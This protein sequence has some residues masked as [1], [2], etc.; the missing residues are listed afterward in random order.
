MPGWRTAPRSLVLAV[1]AAVPCWGR[2]ESLA[3]FSIDPRL[4]GAPHDAQAKQPAADMQSGPTS[5]AAT[6]DPE[7]SAA[8]GP[9]AQGAASPP[10]VSSQP[11]G[12][13]ADGPDTTH[14][15]ARHI[16]GRQDVDLQAYDE[17]RLTRGDLVMT[18]D[19]LFYDQLGNEVTAEGNVVVTRRGDRIAGP[20]AHINLDTWFGEFDTPTYALKREKWVT[21]ETPARGPVRMLRT[22]T[23]TGQADEL[24][25]EGEN[26]YR[27]ANAT[28]S[29][30]PAP[31]PDWYM[32]V[33]DLKLDY[34]RDTGTGMGST[35]VFKDVPIAYLPWAEF[36]LSG[37]RQ[38]GFLPPTV[39]GTSNTGFDL[40][41]PYY[42]N[43]APNYDA[44]FAPRYMSRRG[45]QFG[46]ET[47]YLTAKYH[48][49]LRAEWLP[50][51]NV[52][53]KSRAAV[54]FNHSQNF[55]NGL[56]A[57]V[58]Y[59]KVTDK[60]YFADL[61]SRIGS[62]SQATLNRQLLMSYASGSWL[63][64]S[65]NVQR[66]Q[67]LT[68]AAPYDRLPQITANA[69]VPDYHGFSLALPMQYARFAHDIKDEASRVVLYPQIGF[70]IQQSA[71]FITPKVGVHLSRYEVDRRTTT[72]P[73]S[74]SRS[75]PIFSVDSGL[76]FE[77]DTSWNGKPQIQT[78]E[79]RLYYVRSG[80]TDQS[81]FPVFDSARADFNFAQIF[82]E[83]VYTG[84]DRI[85]DS[86]QL[87]AAVQ[88]RLID[89]D[90]G[91]EWIRGGVGQRIYFSDQRVTLPGEQRRTGRVAD[92]LALLSGRV[93]RSVWLD[94]AVQYDPRNDQTQRAT[95]GVR[96]QP[97]F[98]KVLSVSYRFKNGEFRDLD[99][100]AQ[101]PL[102]QRW[103]GV[104]RYNRNLR[105]HRLTEAIA[106]L[107]YKADCW[108]FRGVWQTL[109]N[110]KQT[111]NDAFFLQIE[112]NGLASIGSS[113]LNLLK[114]SVSG[115]GKINGPG[116][117]D[118]VFG[119]EADD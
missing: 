107:E 22:V 89:A 6:R 31:D 25:L 116:S 28:Y 50:E 87:T 111:R 76:N 9:L 58:T 17:V 94:G 62:T 113:P 80:Y 20:R 83:N 51:D 29:S 73:S 49:I 81:D 63:T 54:A 30:C 44:T 15:E 108:V 95:V 13:S 77:R 67:T 92:L 23:A 34:D 98:A 19:K 39:G 59:N 52:A 37:G 55:G 71:F 18:S 97:D 3:P 5:R 91:E 56:A 42:F 69:L 90:T 110:T 2:A 105:D 24:K 16:T 85:A 79:P 47:R 72:G 7:V 112:F 45:V 48:G 66:Y 65:L 68:G 104:G 96:Y 35:L 53:Q 86:N 61:S 43:L 32:R 26:Q 11:T 109:L 33:R 117:G 36:P 64:G 82:S 103:Y 102:W 88:S 93:Y 21:G 115:Y 27:L 40:T 101:W 70:P 100:T 4:M 106:G 12:E 38:S 84:Q 14:L 8:S 99:I 10:A 60:D 75:V 57:V 78:L 118:P 46:G 119:A 74:L 1:L 114:R 41:V